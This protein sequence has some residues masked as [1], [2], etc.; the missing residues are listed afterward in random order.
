MILLGLP[1]H[2]S[3]THRPPVFGEPGGFFAPFRD[4]A[5]S[6]LGVAYFW[7]GCPAHFP[8][9]TPTASRISMAQHSMSML[10]PRRRAFILDWNTAIYIFGPPR[11]VIRSLS[12]MQCS[13]PRPYHSTACG[14]NA[15]RIDAPILV[16]AKEA[17]GSPQGWW[18]GKSRMLS[19]SLKKMNKAVYGRPSGIVPLSPRNRPLPKVS[20]PVVARAGCFASVEH[21]GFMQ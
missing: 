11:V 16:T 2:R 15:V 3:F 1:D 17:N 5:H 12:T 18:A 6:G 19:N 21:W 4:G 7:I 13:G 10:D 8:H 14:W 20:A 9:R